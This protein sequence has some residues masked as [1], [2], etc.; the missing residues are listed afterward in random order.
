MEELID[1]M[2][3]MIIEQNRDIVEPDVADN[4]IEKIDTDIVKR[5]GR[6][7]KDTNKGKGGTEDNEKEKKQRVTKSA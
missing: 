5:R 1:E 4:A 3:K 2:A 7:K 6:P